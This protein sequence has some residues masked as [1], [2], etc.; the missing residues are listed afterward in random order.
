[1]LPISGTT[2]ESDPSHIIRYW[3]NDICVI[4][5]TT[6]PSGSWWLRSNDAVVPRWRYSSSWSE[7]PSLGCR[8][9]LSLLSLDRP[10][11]GLSLERAA[12]VNTSFPLHGNLSYFLM[13]SF[14]K[15]AVIESQSQQGPW[16]SPRLHVHAAHKQ[17]QDGHIWP[18]QLIYT[19]GIQKHQFHCACC[20][21]HPTE[22]WPQGRAP[23][24]HWLLPTQA[25]GGWTRWHCVLWFGR[26]QHLCP[27]N[28]PICWH[29]ACISNH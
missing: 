23:S 1:M 6:S 22:S 17:G 5:M 27:Q 13:Y 10:E 12:S 24:M 2:E 7:W 29:F 14:Q 19:A 25:A 8:T 3:H 20:A 11:F 15:S 18:S 16:G 4:A 26:N 9:L 21:K 28:L